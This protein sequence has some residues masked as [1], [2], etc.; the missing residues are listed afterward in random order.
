MITDRI[1]VGIRDR[2]LL[3]RLQLEADLTPEK[4]ITTVRQSETVKKQ[5]STLRQDA[6]GITTEASIS[7][8]GKCYVQ[9]SQ[10]TTNKSSTQ[11]SKKFPMKS[12][13]TFCTRCG[14]S[15]P[16]DHSEC[17]AKDAICHNCSK[18]GH[19]KSLCKSPRNVGNVYH[20]DL[21]DEDSPDDVSS[22]FIGVVNDHSSSAWIVSLTMNDHKVEF[23]I[24]TGADVTVISEELCK[25]VGCTLHASSHTLCGPD[26]Q[27]LPVV[28]K[29]IVTLC[30]ASQV[31]Q[32]TVYVVRQLRRLLLGRPAIEEFGLLKRVNAIQL[33]D[34]ILKQRFPNL[35]TGLGKLE[36]NYHIYLKE[37]ARPFSL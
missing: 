32:E 31:I 16:H 33:N 25:Q 23:T 15:P 34:S 27:I 8:I 26:H 17:P 4:A 36:G 7:A 30:K 2:K 13:T 21:S 12:P 9:K 1:V 6:S 19:F 24:D 37:G 22:K 10:K 11:V 20:H 3:E 5:Q 18:R 14:R 35:F 29:G 28:G